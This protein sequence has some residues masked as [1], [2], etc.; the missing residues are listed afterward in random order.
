MRQGTVRLHRD[1]D[2][3]RK[4]IARTHRDNTQDRT[5]FRRDLH[6][7]VD[8]LV[9]RTISTHRDDHFVVLLTRLLCQFS[10]MRRVDR[11]TPICVVILGN[12]GA[13]VVSDCPGVAHIGHGVQDNFNF[14]GHLNSSSMDLKGITP[15]NQNGGL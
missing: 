8:Y 12:D 6:Q 7:A 9:D 14:A 1:V 11:P 10:S 15:R 2:G 3:M 5:R 13:Q 4:V